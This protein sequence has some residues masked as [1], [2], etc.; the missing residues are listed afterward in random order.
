MAAV[1]PHKK[2]GFM[3]KY[4]LYFQDGSCVTKY[5]YRATRPE[6]DYLCRDCDFLERGSRSGSLSQREV[7]QARRDG[8]VSDQEARA[9]T[10]GK[11]ASVYDL[12]SV[13]SAYLDSIRL[14]HTPVAFEKEAAKAGH[15]C[16]WLK[17]NPIPSL[18]DA[19]V[20]RYL[21]D[22][23]EGRIVYRNAKTGFARD[24]V[25]DKTLKNELQTLVGI[26]NEAVR[27]GMVDSNV[28]K[29]VS[30]SVKS[31]TVR[32]A[33]SMSEI[34]RVMNALADNRHLMHGQIFEFV[35]LSLYTGF[36][37][38]ELRTLT[39]DDV[40]LAHRRIVVQSKSI[41]GEGDFTPKSGEARSKSIP[42]KLM[43]VL[44]GMK[45]QGR[46]LFGGDKPYHIDSISQVVRLLMRRAGLPGVSLHHF[47]HTYGSWLLRKTGDLKYVQDELGHLDINTTKKYMHLVESDDPAR[48]FDYE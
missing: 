5:R 37:R 36:R 32:R 21:L 9:L 4:L 17:K 7:A 35:M 46:F 29:G 31:S 24:G 12:E 16:D 2:H 48:S 25:R 6:A 44:E 41:P 8:L 33:L 1:Y 43:P 3:I 23:R 18:V 45:R 38:S 13:L 39:W 22:R 19:D 30:V 26:I 20:K 15:I 28:A 14:S 40:D 27:L 11:L 10:G 34:A 42:D 47:R